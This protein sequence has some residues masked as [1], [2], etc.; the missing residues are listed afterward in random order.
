MLVHLISFIVP[1]NII[2]ESVYSTLSTAS[3]VALAIIP[4]INFR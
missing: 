3:K 4:N 2:D 1:M